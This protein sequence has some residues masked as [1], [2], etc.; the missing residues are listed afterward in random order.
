MTAA[1]YISV[2]S[3]IFSQK[4]LSVSIPRVV[5][6]YPS[7]AAQIAMAGQ[8]NGLDFQ[9]NWFYPPPLNFIELWRASHTIFYFRTV[10]KSFEI[11]SNRLPDHSWIRLL[12][13]P[14]DVF[15]HQYRQ[16][17]MLWKAALEHWPPGDKEYAPDL[18]CYEEYSPPPGQSFC[19]P[20]AKRFAHKWQP[21]PGE[22]S[23]QI[24]KHSL[25]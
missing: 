6:I 23:S 13:T 14:A 4:S 21:S 10:P 25:S 11:R 15:E 5:T 8:A 22:C 19:Y 16:T 1:R 12:R 20:N 3:L 24:H 7:A 18:D 17:R 2:K 9:K